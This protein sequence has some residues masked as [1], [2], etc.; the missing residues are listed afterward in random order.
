MKYKPYRKNQVLVKLQA[1]R[2]RLGRLYVSGLPF[3]ADEHVKKAAQELGK[4]LALFDPQ[5]EIE[6]E[7]S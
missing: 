3:G 5:L 4:A 7:P 6:Y 2:S 1:A